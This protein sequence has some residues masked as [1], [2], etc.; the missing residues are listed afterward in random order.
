MNRPLE[1]VVV[2][3][4][5]AGMAFALRLYALAGQ[6]GAHIAMLSKAVPEQSNSHAAQGGVAAVIHPADSWQQH[7]DDTLAV[8]AGRCDPAVVERVVREGPA[9]IRELLE[10]GARFDTDGQGQ[11]EA[12][13]EGGHRRARVV[14]KGD[15]TG[16]ELVRVLLEQVK[17]TPGIQLDTT[18]LVMDLLTDGEGE[19]RRCC[20]VRT[21]DLAKGTIS[22][23]H[24]DAVVLATGGAGRIYRHTTNPPGATGGGVAMA[25]RAGVPLRDMAFV[26]FHPTALYAPDRPSTFLISEAVRGAGAVLLRHDGSRLMEGK[27][28]MADLAPRNIVARAIHAEMQAAKVPHVWLDTTRIGPERFQ[29]E[30]PM[31]L[32]HCRS[33][34]MDPLHAPLPVMPAAHYLCG[35]IRTDGDGRTEL[36]GLYA[37]GECAGSGLHGADRLASNS[38]LEALVIPRYAAAHVALLPATGELPPSAPEKDRY[39]ITAPSTETTTLRDRL[40]TLMMEQVGIVR[41]DAGLHLASHEL[42]KLELATCAVWDGGE[43]SLELF[44]L[45]NMV[46][47]AQAICAQAIA[48][49]VSVGAHYNRDHRVQSR[50]R[51]ADVG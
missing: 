13:R 3:S 1:V 12:A 29:R 38:L 21:L 24:A 15:S 20:G 45:R 5:V 42:R 10:Q 17:R 7:R 51:S 27:H 47:V 18:H 25:I 46:R 2:G 50:M 31:I 26:Q 22:L 23:L 8:G 37:L 30:F 32:E 6:R 49:P 34:G 11:L 39:R 48:E 33:I 35:G 4:G 44:E 28:P 16:A 36:P 41:D 43:R 40:R 14:H 19:S 9:C